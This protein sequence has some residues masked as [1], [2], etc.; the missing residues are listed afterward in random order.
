MGLSTAYGRRQN[1]EIPDVP[2]QLNE[3][4]N[5]I[6]IQVAKLLNVVVPPDHISTSH[7]L[8][9]KQKTNHRTKDSI[10][11]PSIIVRFTNYDT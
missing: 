6:V 4:T 1:L 3:N 5:S 2:Q 8:Q 11:T 10:C 9:K 7:R